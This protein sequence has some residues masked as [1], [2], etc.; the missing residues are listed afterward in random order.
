MKGAARAGLVT[1]FALLATTSCRRDEKK[2]E[3]PTPPTT[4]A[5]APLA[6]PASPASALV[7]PGFSDAVAVVP[8][9]ITQPAPVMV[10]VL[11][12]G[13]TP[14]SQCAVWRELVGQRA[15]VLCPRGRPHFVRE[16]VAG[17][18]AAGQPATDDDG[19]GAE[20][21]EDAGK[22][23]QSGFYFPDLAA[24]DREVDA[25]LAAL[26]SRY[27]AYVAP[28]PVLY[29][30]FSRGAFLG[31]SLVAKHPGT[32]A[33][34]I[35]IE[36]GQSAWN[37]ATAAA[38]ARNGGKRVLFACGQPSCVSEAEGA[39]AVLARQNVATRIVHGQGEGHGYK[40]QVK[41]QIKE[42]LDWATEGD[43]HWRQLFAA[44][45]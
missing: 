10:A 39:V 2:Q 16:P 6:A 31:A 24:L 1:L 14:E 26:R 20:P 15:F 32:Y 27:A 18:M 42:S 40:L 22:V 23:V 25:G 11:G 8:A 37:D 5:L 13:D 9:G 34:A 7:V 45:R 43:P 38:F 19:D 29:A 44:T 3:R 35:L 17:E 28:G 30:G 12:I 41:D 4:S 36:G 21:A 33:R